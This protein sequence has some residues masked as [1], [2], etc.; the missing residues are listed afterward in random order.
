MRLVTITKGNIYL[1]LLRSRVGNYISSN[2][3]SLVRFLSRVDSCFHTCLR[4]NVEGNILAEWGH[5]GLREKKK[6]CIMHGL[7][8]KVC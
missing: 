6:S 5:Q 8:N 1:L 2:V 3:V 4:S 7:V